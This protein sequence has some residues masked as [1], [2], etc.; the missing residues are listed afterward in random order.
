M[1]VGDAELCARILER[2]SFENPI[3]S[4]VLDYAFRGKNEHP[5]VIPRQTELD[6]AWTGWVRAEAAKRMITYQD[7]K[8]TFEMCSAC[9]N[10]DTMSGDLDLETRPFRSATLG[11]D[12]VAIMAKVI[13]RVQTS[14][15]QQMPP[16]PNEALPAAEIDALQR[17]LSDGLV[18]R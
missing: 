6:P 2:T 5:R 10:P 9:H 13:E 14:G 4:V 11:T 8:S 1:N 18:E 15:E 16:P 7:V 3:G 17:Y 12:Q